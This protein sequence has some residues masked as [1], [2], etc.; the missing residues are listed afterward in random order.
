MRSNNS[1]LYRGLLCLQSYIFEPLQSSSLRRRFV[2]GIAMRKHLKPDKF[3]IFTISMWIV[4][5]CY[6]TD[7]DTDCIAI[8]EQEDQ[9]YTIRVRMASRSRWQRKRPATENVREFV[10]A[11]AILAC[12]SYSDVYTHMYNCRKSIDKYHTP[13]HY[14]CFTFA[15]S[16]YVKIIWNPLKVE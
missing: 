14:S 9:N 5:C 2:F 8:S 7:K 12:Q 6:C 3:Y 13:S 15:I 1:S 10:A 4:H 16:R 11:R